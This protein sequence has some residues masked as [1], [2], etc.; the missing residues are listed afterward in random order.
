MTRYTND[1][2]SA[3]KILDALNDHTINPNMVG[4]HIFRVAPM[5]LH[6]KLEQ[7]IEGIDQAIEYEN[8]R[9]RKKIERSN[10]HA[11]F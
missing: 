2:K 7:V 11:P 6:D 10:Q 1:E 4:Y 8:T 9:E 5:D 3:I